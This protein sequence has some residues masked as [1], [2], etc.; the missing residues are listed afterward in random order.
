M[1]KILLT[2]N[3][4]IEKLDEVKELERMLRLKEGL[5]HLYGWPWYDWAKRAFDSTDREIFIC[6]GN[7][8]SKSS[9]AIRKNIHLATED[10]L[11]KKYW[12]NNMAPCPNLFWYFYPTL[13]VATTEVNTKWIPQFLPRQGYKK[14]KKYKWELWEE[15]G[16]A[17]A[18]V[19]E[20]GVHIQFKSYSMKIK[21]LQTAS[22]YHIT[23]DEEAPA[24]YVPELLARLNATEGYL[25]KVFTATVGQNYWRRVMEPST[26]GEELHPNALK[27][28]VS[29]YD[30][31]KYLDG[32]LSPWTDRKIANAIANCPTPAEV[33]RRIYGRFVKS[34]GLMFESFN[35]DKNMSDPHPLPESWQV[36]SAV[37]PGS[38][39]ASGH[40][41]A[42]LFIAVSPDYRQGRVFRGWRG[43]GIPTAAGD[44]LDKYREL[45]G[46]LQPI[47]QVYDY[48]ARDFFTIASRQ[49]ES[50]LAADKKRDAGIGLVNTLFKNSMLKIQRDDPELQKLVNELCTLSA[51][52]DKRKMLDDLCFSGETLILTRRGHVPMRDIE[53]GDE[54]LT[55]QGFRPI[56]AKTEALGYVIPVTNG[57]RKTWVTPNHKFITQK[58]LRPAISLGPEDSCWVLSEREK[59]RFSSL[60]EKNLEDTLSKKEDTFEPTIGQM[61]PIERPA[62]ERFIRKFLENLRERSDQMMWSIILMAIHLTIVQTILN[63][64]IK[65]SI[66]QN[67]CLSPE[68]LG[69]QDGQLRSPK[70]RRQRGT[71][72]QPPKL[73][74][75]GWGKFHGKIGGILKKNVFFA[76]RP[77]LSLF[78]RGLSRNFAQTTANQKTEGASVRISSKKVVWFVAN[79]SL[80]TNTSG[81]EKPVLSPAVVLCPRSSPR[82]LTVYNIT[83]QGE[84]EYFA[85]DV[86]VA[87]CDALRYAAS[88]IPWDFAG[89][90]GTSIEDTLKKENEPKVSLTPAQKRRQWFMGET[91]TSEEMNDISSEFD[92]WNEVSGASD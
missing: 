19:F 82:L 83:V 63:W 81:S 37:D 65:E 34:Q 72:A 47:L 50:F 9:S 35:L 41:A 8:L 15:K 13:P 5:P 39:G 52:G 60:V 69:A 16:F 21:D 76:A 91:K 43:D 61:G 2:Q 31:K 55:R 42:I 73:F 71:R 49:G 3:D 53:I 90:E 32:S 58:G 20:N 68:T 29:L 48:A 78:K 36:F 18:I 26:P 59:Q 67:T 12:P 88:A 74:T 70:S 17:H 7:Q 66:C 75:R 85:D 28:N 10:K 84:H 57:G 56:V 6:A 79:H 40:P 24:E 1:S 46:K 44:V 51:T 25:L 14:H 33:Q 27:I 62:L 64:L 23:L 4:L 38:G 45:R 92:F 22:V 77:I 80:T 87:N 54:A 11:W 30:C 89:I 86:L